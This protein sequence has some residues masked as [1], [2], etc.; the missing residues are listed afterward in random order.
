METELGMILLDSFL[1][2]DHNLSCGNP[3]PTFFPPTKP[4]HGESLSVPM[5]IDV[6]EKGDPYNSIR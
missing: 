2:C 1:R 5:T 6:L 3:T 4:P